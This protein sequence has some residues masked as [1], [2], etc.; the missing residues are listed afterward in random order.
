M[1][2]MQ[3]LEERRLFMIQMNYSRKMILLLLTMSYRKLLN[4]LQNYLF[5]NYL[6]IFHFSLCH[7][8]IPSNFPY[9]TP[10]LDSPNFIPMQIAGLSA[11]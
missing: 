4:F 6:P 5:N 1:A 10:S 8:V 11:Y 2:R 7:Q 9:I 3:Q